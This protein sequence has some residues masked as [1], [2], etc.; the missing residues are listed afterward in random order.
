MK[1]LKDKYQNNS[2]KRI[3]QYEKLLETL[4]RSDL[5]DKDVRIKETELAL[6]KQKRILSNIKVWKS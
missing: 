5:K 1:T 4:K 6:Q 2:T 3:K